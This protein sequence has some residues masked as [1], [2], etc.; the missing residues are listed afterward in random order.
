MAIC[1][2]QA[3]VAGDTSRP[4]GFPAIGSIE[5]AFTPG[6]AID[7]LIVGAIDAARSKVLVQA[8]SFTHR[9][10]ARA[11]MRARERGVAVAVLADR[12]QARSLPQSAL[13][14]LAA[15]GV[16]V[17]LDGNFQAAHNKVI[18]IDADAQR[19]TKIS[20]SYNFTYA[21]QR[22]NAE[23]IVI[24]RDNPPV[25]RAYRMNWMRLKHACVPLSK[26]AH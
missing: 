18:V 24:L 13:P 3:S 2:A 25:A 20:G 12:E 10:I 1:L 15:G 16:D 17:C 21:A 19:A 14:E 9:R 23:N 11:L 7:D 26:D 5:A 4:Q 6:D 22:S 8:Y